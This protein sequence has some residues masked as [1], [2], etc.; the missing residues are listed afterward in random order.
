MSVKLSNIFYTHF[1]E[2]KDRIPLGGVQGFRALIYA[3]RW[4]IFSL[5]RKRNK[6]N[7]SCNNQV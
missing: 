6:N 3:M 5:S 2:S 4:R 1:K 7:F